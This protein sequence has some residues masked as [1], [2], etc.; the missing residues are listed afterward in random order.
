M[1][2][3]VSSVTR[4]R[5]GQP[6]RAERIVEGE[7]IRLGRGTQCE[8]HLPDPRVSLYHAAIYRQGASIFIQA[9]EADLSVDGG[10][11]REARLAPGAHV[12][13]G[14]YDLTVEPP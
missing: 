11:E 13:L 2:I 10:S 5:K 1:R 14:P 12:A 3:L 7:L 4:N 6:V 8:I 9:P